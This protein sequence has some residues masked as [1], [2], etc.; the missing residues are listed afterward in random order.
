MRV[1][2]SRSADSF[3]VK[4][5][6]PAMTAAIT[7][8]LAFQ[9]CGC[10]YQPPDGDHTCLGYLWMCERRW[11]GG[12]KEGCLRNFTAAAALF[13]WSLLAVCC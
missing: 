8:V 3:Q 1:R 2:T 10:A 4:T 13:I 7:A 11:L 5:T 12:G 6:I 9:L